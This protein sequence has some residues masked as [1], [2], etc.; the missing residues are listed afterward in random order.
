MPR[1]GKPVLTGG[2]P[3]VARC[4]AAGSLIKA[5]NKAT[6]IIF[7][8][9][10]LQGDM[11]QFQG[12]S[13]LAVREEWDEFAV[14]AEDRLVKGK[15][16]KRKKLESLIKSVKRF[17]DFPCKP[18]D[19]IAV[20]A[21][22]S[23]WRAQVAAP[24]TM[25]DTDWCFDPISLLKRR[26]RELVDGWGERL[27]K[28]RDAGLT[29]EREMDE[30][31]GWSGYVPD[32]QGCLETERL[33]G[34]TLGTAPEDYC[35]LDNLVRGGVAKTKGKFRVVTMQSA[36]V[37]ET[38]RPVHNALY[39]HISSFGWC[40][41]G[42]VSREDFD[43]VFADRRP[44]EEIISGDYEQATNLIYLEAVDAI[45]SVLAED[46]RLTSEERKV[47]VGS[48]TD[49]KWVSESGATYPINRGSMM[50]NLISFPLLCLLNKACFDIASD[51]CRGSGANRRGRFNGDD[52][53]FAGNRQFYHCWRMVTGTFG[54]RVNEKKTGVSS[55]WAELNS[56]PCLRTKKGLN[57]RPV[58]SF[59]R[60]FRKEP[61]GLVDEV[62]QGIRTLKKAVRAWVWNVAMRHEISMREINVSNLPSKTL[63]YLLSKK[64]F[65]RALDL[66]PAPVN[67]YGTERK[68]PMVVAN[69]P[70]AAFYDAVTAAAD[71][72]QRETVNKWKGVRLH[73]G[74][75]GAPAR[76]EVD[77]RAFW[78]RDREVPSR[79]SVWY[80][81][82]GERKWQFCWP[83]KL[84]EMFSENYPDELLSDAECMEDWIEDHPFLTTKCALVNLRPKPKYARLNFAPKYT[85]KYNVPYETIPL[86]TIDGVIL[87]VL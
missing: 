67:S 54:L 29:W 25:P 49:L 70:R 51:I 86:L 24:C 81:G 14:E 23:K 30:R 19:E 71:K 87:S 57:P 55:D 60:P 44:G 26:V 46:D 64:W 22:R 27:A 68:V 50:G 34:G 11:P 76:K 8:E 53:L 37:K 84:Y 36:R 65:R 43:V 32:Q 35:P 82:K 80:K 20:E 12:V 40:V 7:A 56:Q 31:R 16:Q 73:E 75:Y 63:Q 48:F 39:D 2:T 38:L 62:Y 66:G 10:R 61:D 28:A 69:P 6:H 77:R 4:T 52:C 13:C 42:D 85:D 5:L 78:K 72:I 83:A 18:C 47:M 45:V 9:F 79:E 21:A 58:I 17:F 15:V 74:P 41:R 33:F 1:G 59:L 3:K